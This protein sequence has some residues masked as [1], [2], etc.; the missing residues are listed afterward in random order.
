MVDPFNDDVVLTSQA[1]NELKILANMADDLK[2]LSSLCSQSAH[3]G[4]SANINHLQ[5]LMVSFCDV[6]VAMEAV[7]QVV[8]F[9]MDVNEDAE[10]VAL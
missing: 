10:E 5:S 7:N 4:G 3:L 6:C 2:V 8:D 9:K 1:I